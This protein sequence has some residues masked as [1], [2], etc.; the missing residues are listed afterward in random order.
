[1]TCTHCGKTHP[2]MNADACR[3]L[4]PVSPPQ[5]CP[6]PPSLAA[7][8]AAGPATELPGLPRM[9]TA[10]EV[11]PPPDLAAYIREHRAKAADEHCRLRPRAHPHLAPRRPPPST[12]STA[13]WPSPVPTTRPPRRWW[14]T[15][16]PRLAHEHY[17][18][19]RQQRVRT[20][21]RPRRPAAGYRARSH[22]RRRR[23]PSRGSRPASVCPAWTNWQRLD[24][25]ARS[26]ARAG[27]ALDAGPWPRA[28]RYTGK[29]GRHRDGGPLP[30]AGRR[31]DARPRAGHGMARPIRAGGGGRRGHRTGTDLR[32]GALAVV[33][34]Q[35]KPELGAPP[36]HR[37]GA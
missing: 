12:N 33:G 8:I 20:A 22:R 19:T 6:E 29:P 31:G 9:A 7:A 15:S 5:P 14:T 10:T 24:S 11:P 28:F 16:T 36:T 37:K 13:C 26:P 1:M 4:R 3:L 25:Q 17:S 30:G 27:G 35:R 34:L 32:R 2:H 18:D 21:G 23:Q